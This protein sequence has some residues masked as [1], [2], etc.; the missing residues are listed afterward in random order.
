MIKVE[1]FISVDK[2]QEYL[3]EDKHFEHMLQTI[4]NVNIET[5]LIVYDDIT[6]N[7]KVKYIDGSNRIINCEFSIENES[8]IQVFEKFLR[9]FRGLFIKLGGIESIETLWDDVG[10]HYAKL[11]YPIIHNIE[12]KM[13]SLITKFMYIKVGSDWT[14]KHIPKDVEDSIK[15]KGIKKSSE[16]IVS[17]FL[18]KVDF[19]QLTNF[20]FE[21]YS[22]NDKNK[23]IDFIKNNKDK[24]MKYN[25]FEEYI[26]VSNWDR[27]FESSIDIE[28]KQLKKKWEQLYELRCKV[29]HNNKVSKTDLDRIEK[30]CKEIE[31]KLDSAVEKLPTIEVEKEEK[32]KIIDKIDE[33]M[34]TQS[35]DSLN[36]EDEYDEI[37]ISKTYNDASI[38]K[39]N[40]EIES[41]VTMIAKCM[42][43]SSKSDIFFNKA[44]FNKKEVDF[45][46]KYTKN[47][48]KSEASSKVEE[49]MK[50]VENEYNLN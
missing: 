4:N 14:V 40:K 37:I 8:N 7:Y 20:L 36:N 6:I 3:I 31:V 10:F 47:I 1:Y 46:F 12:N 48:D 24:E 15:S 25:Q 16:S 34:N 13:R 49:V 27:F 42:Y 44:K 32:N 17:N 18:D 5:N 33:D 50:L 2:K 45:T 11:A 19:I 38:H 41:I 29:A 39:F 22:C 43:S 28:S 26:P 30:L 21:E 35:D 23:I 9:V